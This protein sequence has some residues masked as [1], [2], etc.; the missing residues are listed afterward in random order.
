MFG[1]PSLAHP[2]EVGGVHAAWHPDPW[3]HRGRD[4][5]D[6]DSD[7][8]QYRRKAILACRPNHCLCTCAQRVRLVSASSCRASTHPQFE[9]VRLG[10][11]RS[12]GERD[13]TAGHTRDSRCHKR[14][15]IDA[16]LE[17][18]SGANGAQLDGRAA[19]NRT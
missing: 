2:A 10:L 5:H 14:R 18:A 13:S 3:D 15:S 1:E 11:L 16:Q 8:E 6:D 9:F 12:L 4:Q 17:M 19:E 7:D